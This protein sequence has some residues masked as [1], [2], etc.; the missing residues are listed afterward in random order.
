MGA[1]WACP[2]TGAH[3][4]H[5]FMGSGVSKIRLV[6]KEGWV[7]FERSEVIRRNIYF[8]RDRV[9]EYFPLRSETCLSRVTF[10]YNVQH[11]AFKYLTE[12]GIFIFYPPED[13]NPKDLENWGLWQS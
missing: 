7:T 5:I 11:G 4:L 12:S 9:V 1:F 6:M 8:E 3:R 13:R 10:A 2:V